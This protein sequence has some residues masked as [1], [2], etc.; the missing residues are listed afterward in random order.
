MMILL[1]FPNLIRSQEF[2]T[3]FKILDLYTLYIY[4]YMGFQPALAERVQTH[5]CTWRV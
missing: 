2:F 4:V 3:I 1:D 5:V